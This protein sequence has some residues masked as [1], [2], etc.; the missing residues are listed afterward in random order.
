MKIVE[1]EVIGEL[2][3]L[4]VE[5]D[6]TELKTGGVG[7]INQGA[8]QRYFTEKAPNFKV[9]KCGGLKLDYQKDIVTMRIGVVNNQ[10]KKPSIPGGSKTLLEDYVGQDQKLLNPGYDEIVAQRNELDAENDR[11]VEANLKLVK[12][13]NKVQDLFNEVRD[14]YDEKAQDYEKRGKL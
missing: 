9:K 1:E 8:V 13:S 6:L 2:R 11:L 3:Y 4:T 14:K 7:V 12:E 5:F 10:S